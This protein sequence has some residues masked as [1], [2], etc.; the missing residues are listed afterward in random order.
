MK[1]HFGL[2]LLC[3]V[4]LA[5]IATGAIICH[6]RPTGPPTLAPAQC[7]QVKGQVRALDLADKTVHIAHEDVPG[8]MPAMEMPFAVK[9]PTLLKGLAVGDEVTFRLVV[10]KDDSWLAD[11]KKVSGGP[12]IVKPSSS[13]G[14]G[15]A[16]QM[17][18]VG[19]RVPDFALVDQHGHP[20]HLHDF[21]G[22]AV[23]LTF[24][25]T[26]CPLPNFC[27]LMSRNFASLQERFKRVCPEKTQLLSISFDP[28]FDT[29]ETL[30]RYA[31]LFQHDDKNWLFACGTHEQVERVTSLFGLIREPSQGFIDH[32]LRTALI[33]PEGKLVHIWRSN[34]WTPYEVERM[35]QETLQPAL[36]SLR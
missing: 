14:L 34:V 30:K 17:L 15:P 4:A 31:G 11:I 21:R 32:D 1:L 22:K 12:G 7:F 6:H 36:V 3:A 2:I 27:P 18:R 26:R 24:I 23:V 33:S 13:A 35:V 10:T 9:D 5:A 8:F 29:P 25:Y 20:L 16:A 19:E 28:D